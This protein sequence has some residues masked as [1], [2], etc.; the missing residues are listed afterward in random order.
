MMT[1]AKT[2][3]LLE[4]DLTAYQD[5]LEAAAAQGKAAYDLLFENPPPGIGAHEIDVNK[6]ILRV[7]GEELRLLGYRADQMV[8]HVASEFI[9]MQDYSQ[10]AMDKKLSGAAPLTPFVRAFR[11][12]VGACT[13]LLLDRH[14]R[15]GHGQ[16]IGIRTVLTS[17]D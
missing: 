8:G 17:F 1:A 7:N 11:R 10:R 6:R 4:A 14:I 2:R 15:D 16:I 3:E 5:R 9:L 13:M 12:P